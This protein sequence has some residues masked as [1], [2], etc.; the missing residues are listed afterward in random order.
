MNIRSAK[1]LSLEGCLAI[2]IYVLYD[3]DNESY[4]STFE[5]ILPEDDEGVD[6]AQYYALIEGIG[7]TKYKMDQLMNEIDDIEDEEDDNVDE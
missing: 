6:I 3:Q 7:Y 2:S 1:N 4:V 5:L